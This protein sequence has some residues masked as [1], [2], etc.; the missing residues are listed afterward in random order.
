MMCWAAGAGCPLVAQCAVLNGS[1]WSLHVLAF[2]MQEEERREDRREG[3][4]ERD[5]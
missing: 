5:F 2:P 1:P 3:G 4:R